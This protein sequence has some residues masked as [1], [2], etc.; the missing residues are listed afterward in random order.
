MGRTLLGVRGSDWYRVITTLPLE[1]EARTHTP[2]Y[3]IHRIDVCHATH[4]WTVPNS[5]SVYYTGRMKK[6]SLQ[7]RSRKIASMEKIVPK[8]C[9]GC[10]LLIGDSTWCYCT[11]PLHLEHLSG[12]TLLRYVDFSYA[13]K[14]VLGQIGSDTSKRVRP[15]S[16]HIIAEIGLRNT[17]VE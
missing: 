2:E 11:A 16:F 12:R 4:L 15:T 3:T 7:D 8:M 1:P 17:A 13:G 10:W 14:Y 6:F 9:M 5:N